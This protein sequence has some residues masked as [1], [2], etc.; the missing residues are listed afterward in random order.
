VLDWTDPTNVTALGHWQIPGNPEIKEPGQ[1]CSM[2]SHEFNTWN[3]YVATGNYHAGVW[4]FDAGS[5]ERLTSPVTI[6]YYEPHETPAMEG[7]TRNAPFAWSPDVWGAY[8]DSRGYIL[9]ADWYSGF[10]VLK[11]PG[12]LGA[13]S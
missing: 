1:L 10:Y 9:A 5:P 12:T 6:G 7:G 2:N 4:V 8:F 3:G 13:S 11:F